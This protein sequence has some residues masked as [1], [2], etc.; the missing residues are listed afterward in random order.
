MLGSTRQ[1]LPLGDVTGA[2]GAVGTTATNTMQLSS[3]GTGE[4][5]QKVSRHNPPTPLL[6]RLA[7]GTA[8][9]RARICPP[10]RAVPLPLL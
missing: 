10:S 5:W 2:T 7:R 1:V 8:L 4:H 3:A 6:C 9:D